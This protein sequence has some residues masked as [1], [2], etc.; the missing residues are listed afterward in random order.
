MEALGKFLDQ[1]LLVCNIAQDKMPYV[2]QDIEATYYCFPIIEDKQWDD[3][4]SR[5]GLVESIMVQEGPLMADPCAEE[6]MTLNNKK[7]NDIGK[8]DWL[9]LQDQ[10]KLHDNQMK[11]LVTSH[12]EGQQRSVQAETNTGKWDPPEKGPN[13]QV[14]KMVPSHHGPAYSPKTEYGLGAKTQVT[15][16][17]MLKRTDI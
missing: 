16:M 14:S 10:A 6:Q 17:D 11:E 8:I 4:D 3:L 1:E 12:M 5:M 7:I 13:K 9:E 2:T 15:S